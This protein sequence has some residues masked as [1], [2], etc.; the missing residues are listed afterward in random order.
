MPK[1]TDGTSFSTRESK[2][3]GDLVWQVPSEFAQAYRPK[4]SNGAKI[5]NVMALIS[6]C[7]IKHM[8]KLL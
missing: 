1:A 8:R 4:R 5:P 6:N 3:Y 2:V 7:L